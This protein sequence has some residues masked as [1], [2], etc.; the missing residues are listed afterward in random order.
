MM[1]LWKVLVNLLNHYGRYGAGMV[2]VRGSYEAPV[3]KDLQK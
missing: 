2:S 3:P 1:S